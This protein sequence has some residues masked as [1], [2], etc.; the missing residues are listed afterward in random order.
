MMISKLLALPIVINSVIISNPSVD[1]LQREGAITKPG[2]IASAVE[3]SGGAGQDT[4]GADSG[5]SWWEFG[6][7]DFG[8]WGRRNG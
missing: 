8:R 1:K 7:W 2:F 6:G 3:G 5:S 4:G